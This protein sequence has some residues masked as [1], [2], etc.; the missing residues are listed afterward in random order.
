MVDAKFVPERESKT[1]VF[2]SGGRIR[3]STRKI[4]FSALDP[5]RGF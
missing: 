1:V 5:E 4:D 3:Q 2:G